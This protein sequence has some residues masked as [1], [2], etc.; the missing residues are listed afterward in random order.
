[1]VC[2]KIIKDVSEKL[3]RATR[4]VTKELLFKEA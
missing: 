4:V 1:M 3:A 2:V